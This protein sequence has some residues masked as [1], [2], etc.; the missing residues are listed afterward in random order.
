MRPC[1][2]RASLGRPLGST[3]V[4]SVL[5]VSLRAAFGPVT[6]A[7]YLCCIKG[8]RSERGAAGLPSLSRGGV[9]SSV[10]CWSSG[11]EF[12]VRSGSVGGV[13][14]PCFESQLAPA[15]RGLSPF[16]RSATHR[17]PVRRRFPAEGQ[18]CGNARRAQ[19]S[20]KRCPSSADLALTHYHLERAAT[21]ATGRQARPGEGSCVR[22]YHPWPPGRLAQLVERLPYT[23]VAAGSS[24]APPIPTGHA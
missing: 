3:S 9:R 23:Q 24:P 19:P 14:R 17:K 13:V 7:A 6:V 10:G 20:G 12:S 4:A 8:S 5:P 18:C 1:A 11:R 2:L 15:S 22:R 16:P 21:W